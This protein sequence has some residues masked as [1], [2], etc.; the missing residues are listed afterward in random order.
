MN[1]TNRNYEVLYIVDATLTDEQ[2]EPIIARYTQMVADFGGELQAVGIWDKRRLAYE[3]KG[4]REGIYIQM[5]FIGEPSIA[6]ELDRTLKIA[7]DVIRHLITRVEPQHMDIARIDHPRTAAEQVAPAPAP[8][9]APEAVE[10]TV[11]EETVAEAP[12]EPEAEAVQEAE[13]PAQETAV[14]EI[15]ETPSEEPEAQA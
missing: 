5:N 8:A 7:D 14:A 4:K 15:E 12:A 10:E 13:A 1:T 6:K 3:I 2:V 9:P 11:A